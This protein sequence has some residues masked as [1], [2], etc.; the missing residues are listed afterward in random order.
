VRRAFGHLAG[1]FAGARAVD[2][3]T[4]RIKAYVAARQDEGA[5]NATINKELAALRRGYN[6]LRRAGRLSRAPHVPTLRTDNVRKGFLTA[7]DV[8]AVAAEIGEDLAPVVR[9]AFLTGWRKS[10][11]LSLEWRSVDW[12]AGEIRLDVGSTKNGEGRVFPFGALPPLAELLERN[13]ADVT[14]S[15]SGETDY[16]V[17]GENPGS[18]K[19]EDAEANDVEQLDEAAFRERVLDR[20]DAGGDGP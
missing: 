9:F 20:I 12:K 17:V 19:R 15:V 13:G 3:T 2:I 4:D 16:L 14:S 10:E 6:L 7:A 1:Y 11:I 8:E 18:R 5:A